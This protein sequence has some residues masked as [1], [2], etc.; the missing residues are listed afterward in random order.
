MTTNLTVTPSEPGYGRLSITGSLTMSKAMA[1][2]LIDNGYKI[3]VRLWGGDPS[4]DDMLT[5]PFTARISATHAGLEFHKELLA[6]GNSRLAEHLSAGNL[7]VGARLVDANGAI[8][9]T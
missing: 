1:E 9:A 5:G 4:W 3:V 7:Y 6:I 8:V 2:R